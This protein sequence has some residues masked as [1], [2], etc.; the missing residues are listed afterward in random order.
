MTD[1]KR[2]KLRAH[3]APKVGDGGTVIFDEDELE[4]DIQRAPEAAVQRDGFSPLG[5]P[6]AFG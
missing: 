2:P 4:S 3:Q 5:L 1:E 6:I